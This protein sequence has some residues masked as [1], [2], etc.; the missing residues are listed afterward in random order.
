M[1]WSASDYSVVEDAGELNVSL[2][3]TG[4]I[5]LNC[6]GPVVVTIG[7][8]PISFS[9]TPFN[10][11]TGELGLRTRG[12]GFKLVFACLF[13]VR[14]KRRWRLRFGCGDLLKLTSSSDLPSW[15]RSLD[16]TY[17]RSSRGQCVRRRRVL[18]FGY[19]EHFS[20]RFLC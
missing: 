16:S 8:A 18:L 14:W 4:L 19:H 17:Y 13:F 11:A 7:L 20:S 3:A 15:R 5:G 6:S 9:A 10:I 2:S 1:R 12:G